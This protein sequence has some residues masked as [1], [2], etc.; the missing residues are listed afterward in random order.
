MSGPPLE[1]PSAI[2]VQSL[3][4]LMRASGIEVIKQLMRRG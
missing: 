2:A 1:I 3:S 4:E